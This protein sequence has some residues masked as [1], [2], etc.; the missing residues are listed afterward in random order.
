MRALKITW[1]IFL[2]SFSSLFHIFL[3][4]TSGRCVL[5]R[6]DGDFGCPDDTVDSSGRRFF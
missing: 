1:E 2:W 6:P 5:G 4:E 3:C